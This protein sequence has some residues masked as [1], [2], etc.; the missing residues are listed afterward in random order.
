M[1]IYDGHHQSSLRKKARVQEMDVGPGWQSI[2]NL[3][4]RAEMRRAYQSSVTWPIQRLVLDEHFNAG[5]GNSS[6]IK[7]QGNGLDRGHCTWRR[8]AKMGLKSTRC[9]VV[10]DAIN[11]DGYNGK[12][13]RCRASFVLLLRDGVQG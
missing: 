5:K 4:A 1:W 7:E 8:R 3:P 6:P 10:R 2:G 11:H 12:K 13:E 9:R